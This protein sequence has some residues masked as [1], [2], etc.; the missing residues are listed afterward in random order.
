MAYSRLNFKPLSNAWGNSE[1]LLAT[2]RVS[3][4][5]KKLTCLPAPIDTPALKSTMRVVGSPAAGP[6]PSGNLSRSIETRYLS[7]LP[8]SI[9]AMPL[10]SV[11]PV[12][13][14][15]PFTSATSRVT[16]STGTRV[17]VPFSV[18]RFS[19]VTVMVVLS[20]ACDVDAPRP[21][22]TASAASTVSSS[23]LPR[24]ATRRRRTTWSRVWGGGTRGEYRSV[25]L[26]RRTT[27]V[28]VG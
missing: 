25:V 28:N 1:S 15:T 24:C 10:A 17:V 11:T 4:P 5:R 12:P 27:P 18:T 8:T 20:S 21:T 3:W 14:S 19:T 6:T 26:A 16:P 9:A 2:V 23:C 13:T 7:G 22:N